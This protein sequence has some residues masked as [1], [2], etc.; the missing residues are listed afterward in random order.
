[1]DRGERVD[2]EGPDHPGAHQGDHQH[3][4]AGSPT[5]TQRLPGSATIHLPVQGMN[6]AACVA[7]VEKAL[8]GVPG[9][10]Q[11]TVNLA[12]ERAQVTY[13]PHRTSTG[14]AVAA[15][16]DAGYGVAQITAS[17]PVLGMDCA[18]CATRVGRV[19]Q[20]VPGVTE[21]T[22]N[23]ATE[24]LTVSYLPEVI[25]PAEIARVVEGAGYKLVLPERG[26][27]GESEDLG[28]P[29]VAA[30]AARRKS[31][32]LLL[33]KFIVALAVGAILMLM[34]LIPES[35]LGMERQW[36]VM[37]V[38]ATPVQ[39]WAGWQFYRGAWAA[40]R[41]RTSDMNTLI[42]VGTSAAYLYS[43]AVTFFP[44]A[45][46]E[47]VGAGFEAAVYY[48]SAVIIIGLILLG[49][50][51]EARAKGQTSAAMRRLIGLQAKRARVVREA[52]AQA[53]RGAA[54][55]QDAEA[56]GN[57]DGAQHGDA[58]HG[59]ATAHRAAA[60]EVDIP[61]EEVV[62]GDVV[63]VRPGEKIAVD[64][65]V[66]DGRSAV[67][68]SMLTG[69]SI[70]VEKGPGDEVIGA[71]LNRTGSFRFRATKVGRDTALAQ[72]V[73]LVEEAQGSKAPIQRMA[74]YIASIFVPVVL[75]IAV[76]TFL[77][78]YFVG[79]EPAFTLAL[80]A[81]VSVVIIACPCAMGLATPTAI[82][83]G[84]G[85]GA[86]NG[87][88]IRSGEALERAHKLDVVVLD[89]TGTLT[90]GKPEVT[91]IVV[92]GETTIPAGPIDP[93]SPAATPEDELLRLAASAERGSEHPLGE[94]IVEAAQTRGLELLHA[95]EFAAFPGRGIEAR[96]H[97]PE[98]PT[99]PPLA[100]PPAA[101]GAT[102]PHSGRA[103][104]HLLLGNR[105]LLD[106]RG[107]TLGDLEGRAEHLA[108]EGKT[109]MFVVADGVVVGMIGVADVLKA[110]SIEAVRG[111]EALGLEVY[112]LTGDNRRTAEAIARQ[113][114]IRNVLAEVLPERKAQ[115]VKDLQAAGKV[116]AMVGD[117]I[118][119]A[120]ALAQADI[121]IA[122]G[123]GTDVAMETSDI[124][125]IR[126]DL[127]PIGTAFR[128]SRAT[129]RVIKQNLGWAFGYNIALIPVAAGVLYP[130]FGILLDPVYAAVAMALSSV[131]VLSNS[132]RLRRFRVG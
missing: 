29:G 42:A 53:G 122:I 100:E 97:A 4:Q 50:Y 88:L 78:W 121:G 18:T 109:P 15:V 65:V 23:L 131:S 30:E 17:F 87:I 92:T 74:D 86:E 70:P 118:N 43:A 49:R 38:L 110:D 120:P 94:A 35:W 32:H 8:A 84:T 7:R 14:A 93:M 105:R 21:A 69:E 62:V 76:I 27:G 125:L 126:G 119:D 31:V 124:T 36:L 10:T 71:T 114:G 19:V 75:A 46:E 59:A 11:A 57:S 91:D 5:E 51:L 54:G 2:P 129:M 33:V 20:H 25:T 116:V 103:P 82:V 13:N 73:R 68:E 113:A 132:L 95:S 58:A 127:T 72:I 130:A 34:M 41:H 117:G 52:D 80:L 9:V 108:E 111:L 24:M 85:K 104:I 107:F 39:F 115:A 77:V 28:G 106:D 37:F 128:L 44:G 83:V 89:K 60:L 64:G 112:M 81:F 55:A 67:D 98:P 26:T 101:D 102:S 40:L 16:K 22:V 63:L 3:Q 45:F 1:M 12:T 61:V 90:R 123:T 6:C 66:V 56:H 99:A 96:V 48:D 79:P 47:A